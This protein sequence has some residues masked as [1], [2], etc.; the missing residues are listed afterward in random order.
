VAVLICF[1]A[2]DEPAGRQAFEAPGAV[3]RWTLRP[4]FH[5]ARQIAENIT[6]GRTMRALLA[7]SPLDAVLSFRYAGS[8]S[9]YRG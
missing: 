1:D 3:T 9:Y 5:T 6:A 4:G 7:Q 8:S 2:K